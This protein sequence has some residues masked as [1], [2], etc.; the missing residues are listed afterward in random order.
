MRAAAQRSEP[1]RV[2]GEASPSG[3][4]GRASEGYG[5]GSDA[6]RLWMHIVLQ[7]VVGALTFLRREKARAD[8]AACVR[9]DPGTGWLRRFGGTDKRT[10]RSADTRGHRD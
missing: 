10:P 8:H 9:A 7:L 1:G 5:C 6:M 2:P 4:Q 3:A